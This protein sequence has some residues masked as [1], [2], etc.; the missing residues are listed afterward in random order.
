MG[1]VVW[2]KCTTSAECINL[3]IAAPTDKGPVHK[4]VTPWINFYK[5]ILHTKLFA[6]H[7]LNHDDVS[8]VDCCCIIC[9]P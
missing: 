8:E 6:L 1:S 9:Y 3:S 7:W 4:Y 5:E 2:V